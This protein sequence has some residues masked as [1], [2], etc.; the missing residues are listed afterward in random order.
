MNIRTAALLL[1]GSYLISTSCRAAEEHTYLLG[2]ANARLIKVTVVRDT[3]AEREQVIHCIFTAVADDGGVTS[4]KI[5]AGQTF[6]NETIVEAYDFLSKGRKQLFLKLEFGAP[7]A[8]LYDFDGVSVGKVYST[9]A[10]PGR[11]WA[12]I[13]R[14]K[15]GCV[16]DEQWEP[17]YY[18]FDRD[19]PA[20]FKRSDNVI[21][22]RLRWNGKAFIPIRATSHR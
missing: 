19:G 9:E 10:Y 20:S 1:Y 8:W 11:V 16:M 2:R 15:H 17:K 18:D 12:K 5:D 4:F 21:E 22:R 3:V 7:T 13:Q 6:A 14:T